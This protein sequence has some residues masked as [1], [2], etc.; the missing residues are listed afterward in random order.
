MPLDQNLAAI[1]T[2]CDE[3]DPLLMNLLVEPHS[4]RDDRWAGR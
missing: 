4:Q 2:I 3:E 1:S